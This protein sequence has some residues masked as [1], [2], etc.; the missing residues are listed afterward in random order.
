[1]VA[2]GGA[3]AGGGGG[4][5]GGGGTFMCCGTLQYMAPEVFKDTAHRAPAIDVYALGIIIW[6]IYARKVPYMEYVDAWGVAGS[7]SSFSSI[8]RRTMELARKDVERGV[9]PSLEKLQAG[10]PPGAIKWMKHC[11]AGAAARRPTAAEVAAAFA[12]GAALAAGCAC[13]LCGASAVA[14]TVHSSAHVGSGSPCMLTVKFLHSCYITD[15]CPCGHAVSAHSLC[16][17]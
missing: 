10:T 6:A 3:A 8:S 9:R 15:T 14:P 5:G 16:A 1:M 17:L 7:K 12:D 4:G 13:D 2:G 11:W